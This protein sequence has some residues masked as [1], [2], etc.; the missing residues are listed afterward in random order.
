MAR[1]TKKSN[2]N[3]QTRSNSHTANRRL[4]SKALAN[5]IINNSFIED[6]RFF[7]PQPYKPKTTTAQKAVIGRA[8][9][10][11]TIKRPAPPL[12]QFNAPQE[13]IT[14][15]RR[16]QR[17]EVMHALNKSGKAGQKKPTRNNNSKIKC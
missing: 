9:K 10:T 8:A 3:T 11:T 2:D 5:K 17:K 4:R 13:V 12:K 7:T 15:V 16:K 1:K 6:R 14:C